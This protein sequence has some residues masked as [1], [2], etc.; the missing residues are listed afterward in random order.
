VVNSGNLDDLE[1]EA[2]QGVVQETIGRQHKL[3]EGQPTENE[4]TY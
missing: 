1:Y 2:V 4:E 3:V